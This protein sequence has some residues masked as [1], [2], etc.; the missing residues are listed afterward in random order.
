VSAVCY[1][2]GFADLRI[3]IPLRRDWTPQGLAIPLGRLAP[4]GIVRGVIVQSGTTAGEAMK[5]TDVHRLPTQ[6]LYGDGIDLNGSHYRIVGGSRH[7][8]IVAL[9]RFTDA[10][11]IVSVMLTPSG[12]SFTTADAAHET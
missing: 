9:P 7:D 4:E 3:R 11:A 5:S 2:T 6:S 8:L 1:R 10:V 12:H